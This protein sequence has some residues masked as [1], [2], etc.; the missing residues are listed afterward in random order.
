MKGEVLL[1]AIMGGMGSGFFMGIIF[2][3]VG[4]I[5][6]PTIRHHPPRFLRPL[7]RYSTLATVFI[8]LSGISFLGW[9]LIGVGIGVLYRWVGYT[10]PYSGLGSSNFFF[11]AG[12]LIFT[13]LLL[14]LLLLTSPR[15][16]KEWLILS[17][18]FAAI[19]G[20]LLPLLA[21]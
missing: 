5:M 3:G 6:L 7:L 12:V 20:W 8:P 13:L 15:F 4:A 10:F 11:T 1:L 16:Y 18:S 17:L 9:G 14:P 2:I 19:F 21:S